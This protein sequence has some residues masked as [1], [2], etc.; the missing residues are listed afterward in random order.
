MRYCCLIVLSNDA[1]C[2]QSVLQNDS[3]IWRVLFGDSKLTSRITL[4]LGTSKTSLGLTLK[5]L[6][7]PALLK[8]CTC[9]VALE[10][11]SSPTLS[12]HVPTV[13][14]EAMATGTCV[15]MSEEL[16]EKEPYKKL[17]NGKEVLVV[18]ASDIKKIK[19]AL[20]KIIKSDKLSPE[21]F[22]QT[23]FMLKYKCNI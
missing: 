16:H 8:A 23:L 3:T 7:I 22:E 18:N 17:V 19:A 1:W 20:E 21:Q 6:E 15:L 12:Y 9:I 2:S 10:N 5:T 14:A 11:K 13:P 4:S